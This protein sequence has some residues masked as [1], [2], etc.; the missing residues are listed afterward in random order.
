[1]GDTSKGFVF[2]VVLESYPETDG[3]TSGGA[4]SEAKERPDKF[5]SICVPDSKVQSDTSDSKRSDEHR[6]HNH[7]E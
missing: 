2:E 4:E 5:V 3:E 1:L 7:T 6:S